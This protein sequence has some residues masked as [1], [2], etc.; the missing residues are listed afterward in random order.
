[1]PK[2]TNQILEAAIRGFEAQ[3]VRIDV[4]IAELRAMLKGAPVS[5]PVRGHRG[6]KRRFNPETLQR[7]R[8][9]QQRRWAKARGKAAP[10]AKAAPKFPT[11]AQDERSGPESHRGGPEEALGGEEG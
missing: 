6:G 9:A 3:K 10:Q 4:Q 5:A 1:M 11:E 8:E 7:M 2:L